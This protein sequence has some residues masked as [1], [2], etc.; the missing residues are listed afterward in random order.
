M[1]AGDLKNGVIGLTAEALRPA[2]HDTSSLSPI[3]SWARTKASPLTE[4]IASN[5]VAVIGVNNAYWRPSPVPSGEWQDTNGEMGL[6]YAGANIADYNLQGA[7]SYCCLA[8]LNIEDGSFHT[9]AM[10]RTGAGNVNWSFYFADDGAQPRLYYFHEQGAGTNEEGYSDSF[11]QQDTPYWLGFT[12]NAGAT[13]VQFYVDGEAF[14]TAIT[15]LT[16][17]DGAKSQTLW[18]NQNSAGSSR[19]KGQQMS[20][21]I[22]DA[23]LSAAQMRSK[24]QEMLP[25]SQR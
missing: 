9:L 16:A 12:R 21:Q 23:E 8:Q 15:G 10:N 4:A 1:A 13:S 25:V 14:G 3:G 20:I 18:F 2:L 24:Y 19:I 6:T 17:P 7:M 22:F 11:L 5:D